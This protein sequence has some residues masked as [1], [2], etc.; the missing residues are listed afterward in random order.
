MNC[1]QGDIAVVVRSFAGNEGRVL[2]C[3]RLASRMECEAE[4][5]P[6]WNEDAVWVTD[7]LLRCTFGP[8]TRLYPDSRL[9]PLRDSD[10][11]DE[12]LR[13]VCRP[14]DTRQAA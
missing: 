10:G 11:K 8:A 5:L 12:M 3:L 2:T 6:W 9:R 4:H 7:A 14:V 1:K 13:L